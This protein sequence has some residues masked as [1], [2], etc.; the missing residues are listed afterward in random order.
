M[1]GNFKWFLIQRLF[2]FIR[3]NDES[4]DTNITLI[5]RFFYLFFF[6]FQHQMLLFTYSLSLSCQKHFRAIEKCV[7]FPLEVVARKIAYRIYPSYVV[8]P[9][10]PN[11][12]VSLDYYNLGLSSSP[13]I[14]M[15]Q[16][17]SCYWNQEDWK[18]FEHHDQFLDLHELQ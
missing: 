6:L 1:K 8:S 3:L 14:G 17:L 4:F 10:Y 15:L 18:E 2:C 7:F 13:D 16:L 12:W 9:L 5:S 11:L